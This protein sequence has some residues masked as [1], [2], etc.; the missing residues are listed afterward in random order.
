MRVSGGVR[1]S[2]SGV[3]ER[4]GAVELTVDGEEEDDD[5]IDDEVHLLNV[6]VGHGVRTQQL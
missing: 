3:V 4:G 6:L 1:G 2:G 5:G